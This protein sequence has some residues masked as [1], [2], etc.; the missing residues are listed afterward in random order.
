[1][2]F[3]AA[4]LAP[5]RL[6]LLHELLPGAARFAVLINP[7]ASPSAESMIAELRAAALVIGRRIEVLT[8]NTN[9]EL[10]AAFASLVQKRSRRSWSVPARGPAESFGIESELSREKSDQITF[11]DFTNPDG[12]MGF[13]LNEQS[14]ETLVE[15]NTIAK[16]P[17]QFLACIEHTSLNGGFRHANDLRDFLDRLAMVVDKVDDLSMRRGQL[18]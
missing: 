14:S 8:A 2:G 15:R 5:K 18:I 11:D 4:A 10:D 1:M 13:E 12:V 17:T 16:K 9:Q 7:N 6:G 3:M